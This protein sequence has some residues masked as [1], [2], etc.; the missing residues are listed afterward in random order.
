MSIL[1]ADRSRLRNFGCYLAAILML[2]ALA[3]YVKN[4]EI[5]QFIFITSLFFILIAVIIP[6]LLKY[7]YI[8]WKKIAF[9]SAWVSTR[10][11]LCIVF[12]LVFAPLGLFM[13]LFKFDLLDRQFRPSVTSY[14]K[15]RMR[16]K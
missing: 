1:N 6:G 7:F 13:R 8:F 4:R 2:T 14:W 9:I 3:L 11:F 5:P 15:R 10:L 16:K 12:Y